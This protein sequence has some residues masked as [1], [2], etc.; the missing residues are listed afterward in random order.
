MGGRRH[1][2]LLQSS[3]RALGLGANKHGQCNIPEIPSNLEYVQVATGTAHSVLLRSDGHVVACGDNRAGQ[4][5][6]PSLN[7]GCQYVQVSAA[8]NR[9]LLL[10]SDGKALAIGDTFP[11]LADFPEL[12]GDRKFVQVETGLFHTVL[13]TNDGQMLVR[14]DNEVHE[15]TIPDLHDNQRYVQVSAGDFHVVW[16]LSDGTVV[17]AGDNRYGQCSIPSS[18]DLEYTKVSAGGL[19]TALLRS[20]GRVLTVGNNRC[21]QCDVPDLPAGLIYEDISAGDLHTVLLRSDGRVVA[22]G[23]DHWGQCQ[24]PE[25]EAG[26]VYVPSWPGDHSPIIVQLVPSDADHKHWQCFSLAGRAVLSFA[27]S[28]LCVEEFWTRLTEQFHAPKWKLQVVLSNGELLC[29][30]KLHQICPAYRALGIDQPVPP[31]WVATAGS[32][33]VTS[34]FRGDVSSISGR[35]LLLEEDGDWEV[36]APAE[37]VLSGRQDYPEA[38][39]RITIRSTIYVVLRCP[40]LPEARAF[41]GFRAFK[42]AVGAIEH[43]GTVCHGFPTE[44]T[45]DLVREF[46]L[47]PTDLVALIFSPPTGELGEEALDFIAVPVLAH[48]AGFLLGLPPGAFSEELL[49]KGQQGDADFQVGPSF[50][51]SVPGL[52]E[53]EAGIMRDLSLEVPCLVVDLREQMASYLRKMDPVTDPV[54]SH[55]FLPDHPS[56]SPCTAPWNLPLL[57]SQ[58]GHIA[59]AL[60]ALTAQLQTLTDRQDSLEQRLTGPASAEVVDGADAAEDPDAMRDAG[61]LFTRYV[62]RYGGFS[63][64]REELLVLALV[65]QEQSSLDAGSWTVAYLLTLLEEPPPQLFTGRASSSTS[66]RLRAFAPLCPPAWGTTTLASIKEIDALQARRKELAQASQKA[67][68]PG[69]QDEAPLFGSETPVANAGP[70]PDAERRPNSAQDRALGLVYRLIRA[71]GATEDFHISSAGR[72]NAELIAKL[73]DLSDFLTLM[74]PSAD[75]YGQ[76]FPGMQPQTSGEGP[77]QPYYSLTPSELKLSGTGNFD[78]LPFLSDDL[79]LPF[80]EPDCIFHGIPAPADSFPDVRKESYQAA[81]L[82]GTKALA[83]LSSPSWG[84]KSFL[85]SSGRQSPLVSPHDPEGPR[86]F[87]LFEAIFQGDHLGVEIATCCH[88]RYLSSCGLLQ[89]ACELRADA[90]FP[91]FTSCIEGLIIDDYFSISYE[92]AGLPVTSGSSASGRK[93]LQARAADQ[94]AGLFGSTEK[95]VCKASVAKVGGAE[96]DSSD[97]ARSLGLTLAGAPR[98]KRLSLAAVSLV[99]CSSAFTTDSLHLCLMGGWTSILLY[100]RPLMSVFAR[101]FSLVEGA[102]VTAGSPKVIALPRAVAD[103]LVVVSALAPLA[104]SD[105]RAPLL[106]SVFATDSSEEAAAAVQAPC[107]SRGQLASEHRVH[108]PAR[109][110]SLRFHFLAVGFGLDSL[111]SALAAFGWTVGP[112]LSIKTSPELSLGSPHLV[113]WIAHLLEKGLLDSLASG[114]LLLTFLSTLPLPL[115]PLAG[116]GACGKR[117]LAFKA[118]LWRRAVWTWPRPVHI[119]ILESS[120]VYRLLKSL[121]LEHAQILPCR[122][123]ASA[124]VGLAGHASLTSRGCHDSD[125]GPRIGP[126]ERQTQRLRDRLWNDFLVWLGSQGLN[127]ESVFWASAFDIDFV[128]IVLS[129]YGRGLYKAGRPYSHYSETINAASS[130]HPK[131]RRLLQPSWDVAFAWMRNEPLT[132]TTHQSLK[133]DHPD[134]I[135]II[136]LAFAKLAPG[137]RLW[138]MSAQSFR[139]RYQKILFALKLQSLPKPF[140]KTLDLGSLRAGGAT[141]L[142]MVSEDSEMV[143]RRGRWLTPKIMEIYIQEVSALQFLPSLPQ[144]DRDFLLDWAGLYSMLLFKVKKLQGVPPHMWHSYLC[145][146]LVVNTFDRCLKYPARHAR[147]PR[148]RLMQ[149]LRI[150]EARCQDLDARLELVAKSVCLT[151]GVKMDGEPAARPATKLLLQL[152]RLSRA[153]GLRYPRGLPRK[154]DEPLVFLKW[155]TRTMQPDEVFAQCVDAGPRPRRLCTRRSWLVQACISLLCLLSCQEVFCL[156]GGATEAVLKWRH[157]ILGSVHAA[158]QEALLN[159]LHRLPFGKGI[160]REELPLYMDTLLEFHAE[161]VALGEADEGSDLEVDKQ[162]EKR[163]L[164]A[165]E[166]SRESLRRS[167]AQPKR[168]KPW[169]QLET[170]KDEKKEEQISNELDS[171][172]ISAKGRE[173]A[174]GADRRRQSERPVSSVPARSS[175]QGPWAEEAP[176]LDAESSGLTELEALQSQLAKR[177]SVVVE[178]GSLKTERFK[179]A[180]QAPSSTLPQAQEMTIAWPV[181]PP[182]P[183]GEEDRLKRD[184][185]LQRSPVRPSSWLRELQASWAAGAA[186]ARAERE[187][188]GPEEP[189]SQVQTAEPVTTKDTGV[190]PLVLTPTYFHFRSDT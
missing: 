133:V 31:A 58:I 60:P 83:K 108:S 113:A 181:V 132:V 178:N 159:A 137:Q 51:T 154:E 122:F 87:V 121:A 22:F 6:V 9:T 29:D 105:L 155:E 37:A 96:L 27:V 1:T 92:P 54:E 57:A 180:S 74:G 12:E 185:Q 79:A 182:I 127:A 40:A 158:V 169:R 165:K 125:D 28:E 67:P 152:L 102:S 184:F 78:P 98:S 142:M 8:G 26:E 166:G 85:P 163:V 45:M 149:M 82:V 95:D 186:A 35:E 50:A 112:V 162:N 151:L 7:D 94:E 123:L 43:T 129:K 190:V 119:N 117:E 3:G 164:N 34:F 72:R 93:L 160:I 71:C 24:V 145:P 175:M 49:T 156:P 173:G 30:S 81:D 143:R 141:W 167:P 90:P 88:R 46:L 4:C 76:A 114:P 188:T 80:L 100:R 56:P 144:A 20:D 131:I 47:D 124:L 106:P 21:G 2:V 153:Y 14:A 103:E 18:G 5:D 38:S 135:E 136:E 139:T 55:P 25:P 109:P 23:D 16:L 148:Q 52:E 120:A 101:A 86:Y 126:V 172:S 39:E 157:Y 53:D 176:G 64:Q 70:S 116:L 15:L 66:A 107:G 89:E 91:L 59:E 84:H 65:A 138:P 147:P 128:N 171:I 62:E 134:L 61:P 146:Q 44:V 150:S 77:P 48:S 110:R 33:T 118:M 41:R 179:Q 13:L 187:R 130:L 42:S 189:T 63:G 161:L 99:L 75:P 69:Q 36:V 17:A 115:A 73:G 177:I 32:A 111:P 10:R 19:H 183:E 168:Q 68:S 170:E 104:C 174:A 97:F 140:T 11:P